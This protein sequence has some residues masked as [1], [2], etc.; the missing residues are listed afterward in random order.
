MSAIFKAG[1]VASKRRIIIQKGFGGSQSIEVDRLSF[2]YEI[3]R[4]SNTNILS[5]KNGHIELQ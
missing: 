4:F 1:R 2:N 5:K 3:L